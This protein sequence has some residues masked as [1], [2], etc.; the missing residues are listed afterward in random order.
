M[1][2]VVFSV[3]HSNIRLLLP[4]RNDRDYKGDH[5][6]R[7]RN[8]TR[9]DRSNRPPPPPQQRGPISRDGPQPRMERDQQPRR[10]KDEDVESRMPKYKPDV[11]PVSCFE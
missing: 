6:N 5:Y 11:K 3:N 9:G 8:I 2:Q 4:H 10:D 1:E 7:D